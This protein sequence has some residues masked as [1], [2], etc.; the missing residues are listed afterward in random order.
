[1]N[2]PPKSIKVALKIMCIFMGI[3]P[4]DKISKKTGKVKKSYWRAA[5]G[6]H[7]LGNPSLPREMLEFDRNKLSVETM[8]QV[9]QEIL[10]P[11]FSYEKAFS[12]SRAATG[13]FKWIKFTRDYFYIFKEIEPRRDAYLLSQKQFDEKFEF[14]EGS[15]AGIKKLDHALAGLKEHQQS[16]D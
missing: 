10:S 16:K 11:H 2:K 14:L 4:V 3:Q 1:M 5:Q 15:H 13:I 7:L 8:L 9:E 12:A 6:R